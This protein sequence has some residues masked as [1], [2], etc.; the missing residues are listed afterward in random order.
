M[1][2]PRSLPDVGL[3]PLDKTLNIHSLAWSGPA[4][5]LVIVLQ[6]R[7]F[8]NPADQRVFIRH[9]S[10]LAYREVNLPV[11]R[12]SVHGAVVCASA[13]QLILVA[14]SYRSDDRTGA[15]SAGLF[16][17]ALPGGLPAS[18]PPPALHNPSRDQL[19]RAPWISQLLGASPQGDV[20][21][22]VAAVPNPLPGGH[23]IEYHVAD[24]ARDTGA[25]TLLG[26]LPTAFA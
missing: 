8:V 14:N 17:I 20:I 23:S 26:Q 13:P 22:V 18:L 2:Q 3:P 10:E 6:P 12:P 21:H 11:E 19:A 5:T 4:E 24:Y 16:A 15:D 7:K 9:I 25:L 1:R